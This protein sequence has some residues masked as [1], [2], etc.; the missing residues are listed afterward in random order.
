MKIVKS[1]EDSGLSIK[2]VSETIQ[3]EAKEQREGFLSIL[4]G[5]LGASLS[6]NIL[7][8]KGVNRA[9]MVLKIF[10]LREEKKYSEQVMDLNW[11]FNTAPSFN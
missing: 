10:S 4:L 5:T 7:A 6:G 1:L 3:N 11:I 2:G 9:D 8:G